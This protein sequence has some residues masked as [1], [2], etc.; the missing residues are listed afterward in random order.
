MEALDYIIVFL[1]FGVPALLGAYVLFDKYFSERRGPD[2][3]SYIEGLKAALDSD[4]PRAFAHLRDAVNTDTANT[5]AYLRIGE[6]LRRNRKPERALEIHRDLILRHG[7]TRSEKA[8]I[9]RALTLDYLDLKDIAAATRC[10]NDYI[11]LTGGDH[12][13][14]ST[15]LR[16]QEASGQWEE[17]FATQEK[18]L[19]A[20]ADVSR[21]SLAQYKNRLG[22]QLAE[23][24]E[25]H[26][27]RIAYREAIGLDPHLASAYLAIGD[28]YMAEERVSDAITIW[29][30]LITESPAN[31][32][33]GLERLEKALFEV[34]Q[35]GEIEDICRAILRD[36]PANL[37]GRLRLASFLAK[38]ND[39]VA[40]EEQLLLAADYNPDSSLPV[41][42]L[43]RLY[44]AG[45]Q[46]RK[47][48]KLI[49][50]LEKRESAALSSPLS[51][52][53]SAAG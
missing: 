3:T 37:A 27:S 10:L 12:W 44:I 5:D 53:M 32:G 49:D 21:K 35:F 20:K 17:A 48:T 33:G 19:K 50:M 9:H 8:S 41:L 36:D 11:A 2:R 40:A 13:G 4:D 28:T 39:V 29:K 42:E 7:I 31:A 52:G 34:G 26:K 6:L 15:L 25:Y 14:L 24:G 46:D 45:K 47:I 30:R 38:K 43:A 22:A 51:G 16:I 18:L 1:L 23:R